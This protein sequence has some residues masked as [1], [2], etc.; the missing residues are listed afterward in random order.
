MKRLDV[1]PGEAFLV[2][3]LLHNPFTHSEVFSVSI[4]DPDEGQTNIPELIL[5]H[6]ENRER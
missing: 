1:T 4:N 3:F 6:N 2:P 5:V